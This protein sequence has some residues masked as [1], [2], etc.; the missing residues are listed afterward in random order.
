MEEASHVLWKDG[1]EFVDEMYAFVGGCS[2]RI[3]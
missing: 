2:G 3:S 1:F